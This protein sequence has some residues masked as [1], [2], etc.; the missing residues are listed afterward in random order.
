MDVKKPLGLPSA[1]SSSSGGVLTRLASYNDLDLFIR[2]RKIVSRCDLLLQEKY[3]PS[4][5]GSYLVIN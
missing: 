3:L 4:I 1:V 2:I 5:F